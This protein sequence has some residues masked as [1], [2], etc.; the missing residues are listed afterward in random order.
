MELKI[1]TEEMN[2]LFNRKELRFEL[3]H[4]GE[5]TPKISDVRL[6]IA[7]MT[8]GMSS[9]VVIDKFKTLFGIG[10]T[11]GY[12]RIYENKDEMIDY[13]PE[14]LLKRNGLIEVK[15]GES[16]GKEEEGVKQE[17]KEAAKE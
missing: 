3:I 11:I 13:E 14:Y 17:G 8:G 16:V 15:E 2:K 4:E 9:H 10:R 12:A 1:L 7:S 6:K 5:P